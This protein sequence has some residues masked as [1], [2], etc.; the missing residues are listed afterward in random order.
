MLTDCRS[1]EL[2]SILIPQRAGAYL[3][4]GPSLLSEILAG[5]G[6]HIFCVSVAILFA[7]LEKLKL[8]VMS[9]TR[10]CKVVEIEKRDSRNLCTGENSGRVIFECSP[11]IAVARLVHDAVDGDW[12]GVGRGSVAV[13]R[14]VKG[15]DE[16]QA[17]VVE[18]ALLRQNPAEN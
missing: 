11:G 4:G 14:G 5:K 3:T 9:H 15:R 7:L 8:D 2:Y 12:A 10:C 17:A 6:F 18:T 13:P 16:P 1:Y